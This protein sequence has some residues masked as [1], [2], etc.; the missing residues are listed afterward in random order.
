MAQVFLRPFHTRKGAIKIARSGTQ[1]RFATARGMVEM[2][3]FKMAGKTSS[4]FDKN[5][6]DR[7]EVTIDLQQSMMISPRHV[8][9]H[10]KIGLD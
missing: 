5:R 8:F 9:Q 4:K 7:V 10:H 2:L 6:D 1:V 3:W